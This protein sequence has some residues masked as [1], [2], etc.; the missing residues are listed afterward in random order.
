VFAK[1]ASFSHGDATL[2][3]VGVLFDDGAPGSDGS[4]RSDAGLNIDASEDTSTTME[5]DAGPCDSGPYH[6]IDAEACLTK[7]Y[8]GGGCYL[9]ECRVECPPPPAYGG[10]P[11][12]REEDGG[13]E[14]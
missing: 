2:S 1:D 11:P 12:L 8:Y 13:G 9:F 4:I 14:E 10:V 3:D 6:A 5:T 7:C